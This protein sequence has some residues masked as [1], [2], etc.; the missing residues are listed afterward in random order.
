MAPCAATETTLMTAKVTNHHHRHPPPKSNNQQQGVESSLSLPVAAPS[1]EEL[2][3]HEI[4]VLLLHNSHHHHKHHHRRGGAGAG[5]GGGA[6]TVSTKC[7]PPHCLKLVRLLPGN[8]RCIDCHAHNPQ[9]AAVRYGAL[10]C[11]QC[12]GIHRSLGVQ[13]SSVR[14]IGMDE[15][16]AREVVSMLEGGN[17]QLQSFF[18]RHCLTEDS[19]VRSNV[20]SSSS[21]TTSH[22]R[23]TTGLQ[24]SPQPQS[25][26]PSHGDGTGGSGGLSRDNV[27]RIR[28]KTKAALF[29]RRQM[30]QHVQTILAA[31]PYRG[32]E[33]S[34]L[35]PPPPPPN[36]PPDDNE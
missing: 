33:R 10:L 14:S 31:G 2:A 23:T 20:S 16:S 12:S 8:S 25:Q 3:S 26:P 17:R 6:T 28:Y 27:Q 9:W 1:L 21:T 13:I 15:W 4:E 18:H 5:G 22:H 29:Y 34:R 11:L 35:P 30:E 24:Q 36:P 7:F 32:R 19:L